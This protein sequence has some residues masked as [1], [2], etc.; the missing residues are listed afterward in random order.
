MPERY[1]TIYLRVQDGGSG[2]RQWRGGGVGIAGEKA[3]HGGGLEGWPGRRRT[4]GGECFRGGRWPEGRTR[5]GRL[6]RHGGAGAFFN[7]DK[8]RFLSSF[9]GPRGAEGIVRNGIG[10]E[11]RRRRFRFSCSGGVL[12]SSCACV[13]HERASTSPPWSVLDRQLSRLRYPRPRGYVSASHVGC[14]VSLSSHRMAP[15]PAACPSYI[16]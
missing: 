3:R 11:F 1:P 6:G 12:S 2:R 8:K 5:K 10:H 15:W 4:G 13:R 16:I 9:L 7:V 14:I